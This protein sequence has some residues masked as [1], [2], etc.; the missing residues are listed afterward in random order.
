VILRNPPQARYKGTVLYLDPLMAKAAL[1]LLT[2][3]LGILLVACGSS[4]IN[5]TGAVGNSYLTD[6]TYTPSPTN[7]YSGIGLALS[8]T[9]GSL[10]GNVTT[11]LVA[12]QLP[13]TTLAFDLPATGTIDGANHLNLTATDG[14]VSFALTATLA[15]D[16]TSFSNA[17]YQVSGAEAYPMTS[18]SL[19]Q[20]PRSSATSPTCGGALVGQLM[21]ALGSYSGTLTASSGA[22]VDADIT[23]QQSPT[24][25]P[26]ASKPAPAIITQGREYVFVSGFTVTGS[27]TLTDSVCGVTSASIQ[28]K[29]GY[30]FGNDL[31]VEFDTNTTYK[32]GASL[33]FRID[34]TSG[35]LILVPG[36]FIQEYNQACSI[37]YIAG[38]LNRQS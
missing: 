9:N 12:D 31:V 13:C 16:G 14:I 17:R 1:G 10:S 23:L 6:P 11:Y 20:S 15:G 29:E 38:Q 26:G 25:L 34:P 3:P 8:N 2:L 27:M 21:P 5:R 37:P 30:L 28:P 22:I 33:A 32:T 35:S 7:P 4:P 19:L 18:A 36:I 24:P